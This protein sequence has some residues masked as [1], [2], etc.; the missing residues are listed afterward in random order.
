[1]IL[2]K[3]QLQE[4]LAR[5]LISNNSIILLGD[6]VLRFVLYYERVKAVIRKAAIFSANSLGKN[7]Y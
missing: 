1:M 2:V 5:K 7:K 6:R 4:Q 3:V